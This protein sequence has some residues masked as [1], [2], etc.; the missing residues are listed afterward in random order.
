MQ[1]SFFTFSHLNVI[2]FLSVVYPS[3]KTNVNRLLLYVCI[4]FCLCVSVAQ[5][6]HMSIWASA[7]CI[8]FVMFFVCVKL[9]VLC[10]LCETLTKYQ[11]TLV[12]VECADKNNE[13][14]ANRH[15]VKTVKGFQVRADTARR[16]CIWRSRKAKQTAEEK[17]IPKASQWLSLMYFYANQT[18]WFDLKKRITTR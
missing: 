11:V 16:Y 6:Q 10:W 13:T 8:V 12:I 18:H 5:C 14:F 1:F 3:E 15:S 17:Q 9:S 7:L 4:S 2:L